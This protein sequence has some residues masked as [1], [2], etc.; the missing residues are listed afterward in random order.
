MGKRREGPNP[1][2][3]TSQR[4]CAWQKTVCPTT[5]WQTGCTAVFFPPNWNDAKPSLVTIRLALRQVNPDL[6]L[7]S[8]RR[9]G[10]QFVAQM[11][12]STQTLMCHWGHTTEALLQRCLGYVKLTLP[13]ARERLVCE[14]FCCRQN[15]SYLT[16]KRVGTRERRDMKQAR[17][18][19]SRGGP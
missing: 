11:G 14:E 12:A 8:V 10:L 17:G 5:G 1:S 15:L 9:G 16:T 6:G 19:S 3:Y 4:Q 13:A 7:L 2:P 18:V